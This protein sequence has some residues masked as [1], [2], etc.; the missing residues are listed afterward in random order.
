[1]SMRLLFIFFGIDLFFI[2]LHLVLGASYD[3]F[4]LDRERTPAALWSAF[5]LA[6][7]AYALLIITIAS[8]QS[9]QRMLWTTAAIVFI[10][11]SFDEISEF[12]ENI[13]Y[14]LVTYIPPLPFL[15]S[16]TPMWAIFMSPL[17][18]AVCGLL[19]L[20]IR[21]LFRHRR[22]LGWCASSALSLFV[23]ALALEFL[24]GIRSL[25]SFLPVLVI[26]EEAFEL[27]AESL[28]LFSLSIFAR[29]RFFS[30]YEVKQL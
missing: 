17:I 19:I 25:E 7:C 21:E 16:G 6:G 2:V 24:G 18:I 14:Y 9:I 5:Q 20:V 29:D 22:I 10:L 4:N 30:R 23:I 27:A 28:F 12:H 1:M 26:I 3:L 15:W 8:S 13:V 11:L